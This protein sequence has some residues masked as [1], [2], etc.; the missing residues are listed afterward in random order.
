MAAGGR[1]RRERYGAGGMSEMDTAYSTHSQNQRLLD[2]KSP[3]K[4]TKFPLDPFLQFK[5]G[6]WGKHRNGE[7]VSFP[8]MHDSPIIYITTEPKMWFSC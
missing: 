4:H 5:V 3:I 2:G 7:A 1:I 8:G 6:E